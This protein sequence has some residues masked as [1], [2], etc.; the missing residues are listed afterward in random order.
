MRTNQ[1]LQKNLYRSFQQQFIQ[2][3]V[4]VIQDFMG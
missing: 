2:I 1:L 4:K 3:G